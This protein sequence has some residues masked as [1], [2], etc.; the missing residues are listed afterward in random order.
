MLFSTSSPKVIFEAAK[1][2]VYEITG[3]DDE[4]LHS[5]IDKNY[6]MEYYHTVANIREIDFFWPNQ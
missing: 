1:F 4:H 6:S 5:N 2:K 3:Y